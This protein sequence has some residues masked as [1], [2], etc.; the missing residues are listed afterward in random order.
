[1][2]LKYN[3]SKNYSENGKNYLINVQIRL[4][5]EC[6]NKICEFAITGKVYEEVPYEEYIKPYNKGDRIIIDNKYFVLM[7]CGCCHDEIEKQFP[8]FKQFIDL[9]LVNHYGHRNI[10]NGMFWFKEK[11]D[12]KA[13][14]TICPPRSKVTSFNL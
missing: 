2:G 13:K 11:E 7:C 8:E 1:M 4:N 10:G 14:K 6:K 9:H 3:T 12:D 5:D